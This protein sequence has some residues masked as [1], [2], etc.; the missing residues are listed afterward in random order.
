MAG[1]RGNYA[2]VSPSYDLVIVRRGLDRS[3]MSV[4]DMVAEV[5]KAFP[6]REGGAKPERV[7]EGVGR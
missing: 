4:W 5:L 3:G 2:V 1:A 7:C 6:G